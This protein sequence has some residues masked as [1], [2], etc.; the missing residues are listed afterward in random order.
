MRKR[1]IRFKITLWFTAIITVM[2]IIT[3]MVILS[4]SGSVMQNTIRDN[5]I[6][7]VINNVDEV[8]Y[9]NDLKRVENDNDADRYI[10]YNEGYLEID[11]DY[12]EMV[13]KISTTLYY[14]N[15]MSI[16]GD[17]A[18]VKGT[19]D[20]SFQ[21]GK[22]QRVSLNNTRYYIYDKKLT[23]KG[24]DGLWLRGVVSEEQGAVQLSSITRLS[25]YILPCLLVL[26]V[27]GGCVIAGRTLKPIRDME[28]VAGNIVRGQD[29]KKR[30]ELSP[31]TDELRRLATTFNEMFERLDKSFESEQQFA[32]DVS[33]ELRTPMSVIEAQCEF[34]LE[35]TR[36]NE[37]YVSALH[38]IKRQSAK[39]NSIIEKMLSFVRL[40]SNLNYYKKD[41]ID[42]SRLVSSI[43]EDMALLREKNIQ[44]S[45]EIEENVIVNGNEEL[46]SRLLT[47]LISNAY[48]YGKE[49]GRIRV[50]LN[51]TEQNVTVSVYDNG[52]GIPTDKREKIF[53][54]FYQVDPSRS[55][56][57]SGL[58]LAMVQ[59]IA[60]FHG[61]SVQVESELN[62]GSTFTFSM[63]MVRA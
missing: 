29:L 32:S 11:D 37:E 53:R 31:G 41:E 54:R 28:N 30:I 55:G 34:T 46:L 39:M 44:L 25:L 48:R 58:G 50:K 23:Q 20:Y 51:I 36:T 47:N 18:I 15:G 10:E 19:K 38:V 27:F 7:T 45:Y 40:E 9:F 4:V 24:L 8:E 63:K 22:I 5:L 2:V 1:S 26:A 57:G 17:N 43:C 62:K 16:Y 33:H 61:G 3:Y 14:E 60:R 6:E 12:L 21:D 56:V 35:S 13:N 49:N 52:I 42:Y 59:E